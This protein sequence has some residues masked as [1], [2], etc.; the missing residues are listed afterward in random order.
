MALD[1]VFDG[2]RHVVVLPLQSILE[3]T[4]RLA[5]RHE[6][7]CRLERWFSNQ[8]ALQLTFFLEC[9]G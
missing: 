2:S 9:E 5:S 4:N 7:S 1:V 8:I 3:L 6:R